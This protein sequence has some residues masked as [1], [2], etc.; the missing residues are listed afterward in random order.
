MF[1]EGSTPAIIRID[2]EDLGSCTTIQ[3][4]SDIPETFCPESPLLADSVKDTEWEAADKEITLIVIPTVAPLP[5]GT[6]IKSTILDDNFIKEMHAISPEHG[7]WA[8]M[9]ADAHEQ[10]ATDF[11]T[12]AIVKNLSAKPSSARRDPCRAATKGF[13]DATHT[14]SG[15]IVDTSRPGKKHE[16]EQKILKES[17]Y[18]NPTPARVKVEEE[19]DDN[20]P[21]IPVQ[22]SMSTAGIPVQPSTLTAGA[23]VQSANQHAPIA[24]NPPSA[25][26]YSQ[27]LETLKMINQI[28]PQQ[29]KIVVES[30]K[31]EESVN[32]A[33][34][35]TSMLKLFY[36]NGKIDWDEGT[37][38]NVILATFAKGFKDLLG[39]TATVQEAQFANLLNTNFKSLP[40]KDEDKL[41]NP[42]ER[43][44]SL[45]VFPK[46]FTKAHLNA[47]FQSADLETNMMYKNTS[48]NSFPLRST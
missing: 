31:Y 3:I 1:D 19:D 20:A 8:K 9:M 44:M 2:G 15:P 34:L 32:L 48:V 12:S 24:A 38:K 7:F 30:R 11:D 22:S 10:Y 42:L 23:S 25:K 4:F 35:Q 46:K 41:A 29:Q 18:R 43:L 13:R 39:R 33:K 45:S 6:D 28:A 36:V 14:T 21:E 47:S 16:T 26:L 40:D 37:V 27:L 5:Y 17:F